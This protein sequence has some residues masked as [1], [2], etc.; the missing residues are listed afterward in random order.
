MVRGTRSQQP[1]LAAPF[2]P[3]AERVS[4]P[5]KSPEGR[6]YVLKRRLNCSR[7]VR[8][9]GIKRSYRRRLDITVGGPTILAPLR[10]GA[11]ETSTP[12]SWIGKVRPP[13]VYGPR[14]RGRQG[15]GVLKSPYSVRMRL[16]VAVSWSVVL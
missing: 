13:T 11:Y 7:S 14:K 12:G 6:L 10:V 1:V 8:S 4:K 3:S 16:N 15:S 2:T 5:P 9:G